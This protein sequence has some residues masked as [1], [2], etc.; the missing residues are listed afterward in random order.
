MKEW[1]V[2]KMHTP[3]FTVLFQE[4]HKQTSLIYITSTSLS[5]SDIALSPSEALNSASGLT[6]SSR[7]I[8]LK[9]TL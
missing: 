9:D 8:S 2:Q 4:R 5:L 7:T 6:L 3:L 1:Y